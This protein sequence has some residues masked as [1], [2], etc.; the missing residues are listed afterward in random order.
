MGD[1]MN[2]YHFTDTARLPWIFTSGELKPGRNKIGGFP[3]P[4][5]IWATTSAAGDRTASSMKGDA[6]VSAYRRGAT[7]LVRFTLRVEDFHQ[8]RAIARLYPA[9]TENCITRLER[10]AGS[11]SDP[12]TWWCRAE[13]LSRPRWLGVD[14]RS[15]V[16]PDWKPLS[17]DTEIFEGPIKGSLGIIVSGKPFMSAQREFPNGATGYA[18]L[19]ADP[20]GRQEARQ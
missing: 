17:P 8:W 5:F 18:M 3:D 15:F 6:A 19:V 12:A 7:R 20:I 1:I 2:I 11:E 9:W 16:S 10:S 14:T 4:D 13:P